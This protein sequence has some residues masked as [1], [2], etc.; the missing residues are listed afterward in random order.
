MP[1]ST[2]AVPF[3]VGKIEEGI[4]IL[5]SDDLQLVEFPT[6]CLPTRAGPIGIGSVL[7][8]QLDHSLATETARRD[9]FLRLQKDILG[10]YGVPPDGLVFSQEMLREETLGH[11]CIVVGW[12]SW[13]ELRRQHGWHAKLLSLDCYLNDTAIFTG[14]RAAPPLTQLSLP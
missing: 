3:T 10:K 2:E 7:S 6:D 4:A 8:L 11:E 13:A 9:D 14:T 1:V 12:T 5:V